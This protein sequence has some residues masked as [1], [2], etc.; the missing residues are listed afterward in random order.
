M[1]PY[2]DD[3]LGF[4]SGTYSTL[5]VEFLILSTGTAMVSGEADPKCRITLPP[6]EGGMSEILY[7][8]ISI[9]LDVS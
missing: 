4:F 3:E 9:R 2:W 7:G 6:L 1:V 8:A 5:V